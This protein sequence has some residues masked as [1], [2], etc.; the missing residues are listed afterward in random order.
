MPYC[1]LYDRA[2]ITGSLHGS[3]LMIFLSWR[4]HR[5]I[6]FWFDFIS[7]SNP[8]RNLSDQLQTQARTNV[9]MSKWCRHD[10]ARPHCFILTE[11]CS[12]RLELAYFA[13]KKS[14]NRLV[15]KNA[16]VFAYYGSCRFLVMGSCLYMFM[17]CWTNPG[18]NERNGSIKT[19]EGPVCFAHFVSSRHIFCE[20]KCP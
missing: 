7:N 15:W 6:Y 5:P 8:H 10:L 14:K 11:A 20:F 2:S 9:D 1:Y 17:G 12:C 3:C 16:F 18:K 13:G 4:F 19:H